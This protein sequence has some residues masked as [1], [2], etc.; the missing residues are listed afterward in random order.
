MM[1]H[2]CHI[3]L[4]NPPSSQLPFSTTDHFAFY[5]PQIFPPHNQ[6]IYSRPQHGILVSVA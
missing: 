4:H 2:K 3:Y 6:L 5:Q 1:R